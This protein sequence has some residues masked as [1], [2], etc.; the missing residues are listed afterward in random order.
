MKKVF[1]KY[2]GIFEN[3]SIEKI[4]SLL[5]CVDE[6]IEF[7]DPFNSI[8]GKKKF[9]ELLLEMF[10]N[11]KDPHFKILTLSQ[12]NNTFFLKWSF[13]GFYKKQFNIIGLSEIII[14]NNHVIKHID[15][16]DSGKN[17]YCHLPIIGRIFRKIHKIS[18]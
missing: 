3:L 15:F 6:N 2:I 1:D 7:S 11:I 10:H 5:E 8:V 12:N 17:F 18:N 9:E 14:K 16:W 4:D 13:K